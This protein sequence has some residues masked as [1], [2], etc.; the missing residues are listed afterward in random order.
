MKTSVKAASILL[1]TPIFLFLAVNVAFAGWMCCAAGGPDGTSA[2]QPCGACGDEL[3]L[4]SVSAGGTS[5]C[6]SNT[7]CSICTGDKP[8]ASQCTPSSGGGTGAT[9]TQAVYSLTNPTNLEVGNT[10]DFYADGRAT[11]GNFSR[12]TATLTNIVTG[13][14]VIGTVATTGGPTCYANGNCRQNF[15]ITARANGTALLKVTTRVRLCPACAESGSCTQTY[16]VNVGAST[17]R[18][19]KPGAVCT[20]DT[21]TYRVGS[22]V[23]C[24]MPVLTDAEKAGGSV[25]YFQQCTPFKGTTAQTVISKSSVTGSFAPITIASGV[26]AMNCSFRHCVTATSGVTSCSE[27]GKAN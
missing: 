6:G 25:G 1:S 5:S 19:C 11:N 9:C 26:T 12:M 27:W 23:T 15:R 4:S 7:N 24:T 8:A 20:S 13:G 14:P 16:T 17:A 3:K 2:V 10:K 18:T 22:K 21:G